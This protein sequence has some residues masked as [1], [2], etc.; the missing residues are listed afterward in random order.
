MFFMNCSSWPEEVALP[1]SGFCCSLK[2]KW[3]FNESLAMQKNQLGTK[4]L[5]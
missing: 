5:I 2:A 3:S 1:V 4:M